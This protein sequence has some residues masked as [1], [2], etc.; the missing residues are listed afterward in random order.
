M[1]PPSTELLNRET[2]ES[3]SIFLSHTLYLA[4]QQLLSVHP[5]TYLHSV[6]LSVP[7]GH[8]QVTHSF[9]AP[10]WSHSELFK[11][12]TAPVPQARSWLHPI[13]NLSVAAC[14]RAIAY[15]PLYN[16]FLGS[17]LHLVPPTVPGFMSSSSSSYFLA[18]LYNN[19]SICLLVLCLTPHLFNIWLFSPN[20]P[21]TYETKDHNCLI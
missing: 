15:K 5:Q 1:V 6:Q 12:H 10:P 4:H 8:C 2:C 16:L 21:A 14:H 7:G 20:A 17:C 18:I 11:I 9:S 13:P 3:S 19:I